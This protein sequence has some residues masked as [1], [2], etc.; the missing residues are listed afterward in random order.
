[1]HSAAFGLPFRCLLFGTFPVRGC[2]SL[3][4]PY[5]SVWLAETCCK[6]E[7]PATFFFRVTYTQLE[8]QIDPFIADFSTLIYIILESV[9]HSAIRTYEPRAH[10]IYAFLQQQC[11]Y[12]ARVVLSHGGCSNCNRSS[13]RYW[14]VGQRDPR[15]LQ[16][17]VGTPV[18][19]ME[20]SAL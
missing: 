16:S 8:P 4:M 15:S 14:S 12:G 20:L 10:L 18:W 13:S 2:C 9:K 5:Y 3:S 6:K 11:I 7:P 19:K 17:S 1:M